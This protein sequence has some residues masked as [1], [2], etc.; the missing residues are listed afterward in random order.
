M[1]GCIGRLFP[2]F[3]PNG[4]CAVL[5]CG[6]TTEVERQQTPLLDDFVLLS[7][8]FSLALGAKE[9]QKPSQGVYATS[10]SHAMCPGAL[11]E[12]SLAL[13]WAVQLL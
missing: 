1:L 11:K 5:P 9:P 12:K 7:S 10:V 6:S 8:L 4:T 3:V 2:A 13:A